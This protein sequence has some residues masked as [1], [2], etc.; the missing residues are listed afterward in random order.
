MSFS[1]NAQ[2]TVLQL[3]KRLFALKKHFTKLINHQIISAKKKKKIRLQDNSMNKQK[4][5]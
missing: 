4:T 1:K 5:P 3:Q 2:L